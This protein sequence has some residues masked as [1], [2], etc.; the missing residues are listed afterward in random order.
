MK[1]GE[2]VGAIAHLLV[3]GNSLLHYPIRSFTASAVLARLMWTPT[4]SCSLCVQ[5]VVL[6]QRLTRTGLMRPP[7]LP[8]LERSNEFRQLA[9]PQ[10]EFM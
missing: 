6:Q 10:P 7:N 3:L 1:C 8:A 4:Q 5:P 2:L 9:S